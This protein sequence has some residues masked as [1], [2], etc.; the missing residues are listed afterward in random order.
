MALSR[1]L[2]II[3][4]AFSTIFSTIAVEEYIVGDDYGWRTLFDYQAWAADKNFYVGD[5][6]VFKY[7]PGWDNVV[8]VNPDEF[9]TCSVSP[10]AITL[11]SGEDEII[12]GG[13]GARW[14]ISS[15]GNHCKLGQKLAI[16]VWPAWSPPLPSPAPWTQPPYAPW[17]PITPSAHPPYTPPAPWTP[18][19]PSIVTPP[20]PLTPIMPPS[21][22]PYAPSAPWTPI[23]PSV[24]PPYAP[25]I[26][27][28]PAPWTPITPSAEPP[29]APWTPIT[30]STESPYAPQI[31]PTPIAQA[32]R[33]PGTPSSSIPLAP[34]PSSK[35]RYASRTTSFSHFAR[36]MP[37]KPF[38]ISR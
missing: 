26:A 23:T 20:A 2:I 33:T 21:E 36:S 5:R 35:L 32:P 8:R 6:I 25:S 7:V 17:T 16:Y 38:K 12:F 27:T 10:N 15:I 14:Y 22:P 37:K 28:P 11:S 1:T 3:L 30:P 9:I 4:V 19:T 13:T 18:I 34:A 31:I 29:Y 24:E